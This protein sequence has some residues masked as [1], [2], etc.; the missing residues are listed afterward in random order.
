[1]PRHVSLSKIRCDA[2]QSSCDT[3]SLVVTYFCLVIRRVI[4]TAYSRDS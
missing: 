4:D 1:M 3:G 2:R